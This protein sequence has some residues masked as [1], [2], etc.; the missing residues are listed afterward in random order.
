MTPCDC[1]LCRCARRERV[2]NRWLSRPLPWWRRYNRWDWVFVALCLM[3]ATM[4]M[5]EMVRG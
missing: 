4:C 2:E 1:R 5:W 3:G